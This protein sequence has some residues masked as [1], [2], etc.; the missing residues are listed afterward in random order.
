MVRTVPPS[1]ASHTVAMFKFN[2]FYGPWRVCRIE[3][4]DCAQLREAD[5]VLS[6]DFAPDINHVQNAHVD[7]GLNA[8][9]PC[10]ATLELDATAQP[11]LRVYPDA[12][13]LDQLACWRSSG[14]DAASCRR[15]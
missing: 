12:M 8:D 7:D 10:I 4:D 9:R 5:F 2:R 11:K 13:T 3:E 6:A 15:S 14:F 1:G